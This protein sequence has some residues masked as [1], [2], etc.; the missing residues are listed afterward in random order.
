MTATMVAGT[1]KSRIQNCQLAI[2]KSPGIQRFIHRVGPH[3]GPAAGCGDVL[4]LV[5]RTTTAGSANALRLPASAKRID[6][7]C[8]R[9]SD[10]IALVVGQQVRAN[11]PRNIEGKA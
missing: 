10:G 4:P 8:K 5:S 9:C 7:G 11:V 3:P 6:D 2:S 1:R